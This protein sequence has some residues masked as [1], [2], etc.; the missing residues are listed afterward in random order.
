VDGQQVASCLQQRLVHGEEVA[1]R[2]LRRARQVGGRA[3]VVIEGVVVGEIGLAVGASAPVDVQRDLVQVV[4]RHHVGG[5]VMRRVRDHCDFR[6][7]EEPILA[8]WPG[9]S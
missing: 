8:P 6:H 9:C 2:R 7:G 5:E 4:A 1:H 3:H